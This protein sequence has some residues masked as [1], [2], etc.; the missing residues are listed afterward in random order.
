MRSGRWRRWGSA[1][2]SSSRI[3]ASR[4][5]TGVL[6]DETIS[7][8][9]ATIDAIG[10]ITRNVPSSVTSARESTMRSPG[11]R[12][13]NCDSMRTRSC[14]T[15]GSI[16]DA[17]AF[18]ESG[19]LGYSATASGRR[20]DGITLTT[21]SWRVAPLAPDAGM[22]EH[23]DRWYLLMGVDLNEYRDHMRR[24]SVKWET[25]SLPAGDFR[26]LARPLESWL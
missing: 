19:S 17:S 25:V 10:E 16:G 2:T 20:L 18:F 13:P 1:A 15:V 24:R 23:R 3:I 26:S 12:I 21:E 6:D 11:R 9:A 14:K 8:A 22:F 7:L 5:M 4:S